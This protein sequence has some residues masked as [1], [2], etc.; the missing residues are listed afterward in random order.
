MRGGS[1]GPT[2]RP[3][4]QLFGIGIGRANDDPR[5]NHAGM[6]RCFDV[7]VTVATALAK[8]RVYSTA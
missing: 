2:S 6:L 4:L 8:R 3:S 1:R 5:F 7:A